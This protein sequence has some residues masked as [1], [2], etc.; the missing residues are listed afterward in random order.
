MY[1]SL[2]QIVFQLQYEPLFKIYTFYLQQSLYNGFHLLQLLNA[3]ICSLTTLFVKCIKLRQILSQFSATN[4]AQVLDIN[5][6][7]R[8]YS[9][10]NNPIPSQDI[11]LQYIQK[12]YCREQG[13]HLMQRKGRTLLALHFLKKTILPRIFFHLVPKGYIFNKVQKPDGVVTYIDLVDS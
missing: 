10:L 9:D 8:D 12:V 13:Q 3:V 4:I 5:I 11:N 1:F 7:G 6:L 2:R